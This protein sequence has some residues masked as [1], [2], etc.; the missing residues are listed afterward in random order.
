[1]AVVDGV[2]Y[3]IDLWDV[4]WPEYPRGIKMNDWRVL[5]SRLIAIGPVV[6]LC[7]FS[8]DSLP[9]FNRIGSYWYPTMTDYI[10]PSPPIIVVATNIEMRDGD[11]KENRDD[12]KSDEIVRFE[13]G[14]EMAG[15]VSAVKYLEVSD[16]DSSAVEAVFLEVVRASFRPV[17]SNRSGN[18]CTIQ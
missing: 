16:K 7:W 15:R 11:S 13:Q 6:I 9:S 18:K 3:N 5:T 10:A 1:M 12:L 17:S 8:V 14:K 4:A 2:E